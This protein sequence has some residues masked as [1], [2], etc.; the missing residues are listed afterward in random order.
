MLFLYLG[1][2]QNPMIR[3]YL[4]AAIVLASLSLSAQT[5][6]KTVEK[7]MSFLASD[8]LQGRK[9]G[10]EGIDAAATYIE[11]YFK[12]NNVAP[13]FN[14][15]KDTLTTTNETAYNI[16]G[17]VPGT[18]SNLKN[19]YIVIGAHYDHIGRI[20]AENGDEIANGANDNASG[21][22][23]V[24]EY[25]K[26]FAKHPAK[27]SVL[28]VLFSA[29]EAGLLGS[30]HLASKLKNQHFNLYCMVNFEMIGV[31]MQTDHV[32]YLT[33]YNESNMASVLN[34]F[35]NEKVVG[36]LETAKKYQLYKRSDNYPFFKEFGAPSQTVCTFDFTNFEYYHKVDDELSEMD[37]DHMTRFINTFIP[38][39][40]KLANTQEAVVKMN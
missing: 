29:E 30:T 11:D 4:C 31:P 28:F 34:S 35:S 22:T 5:K 14:T 23:A 39:L 7:H 3:K 13:Y 20:Q 16:V 37:F 9:V 27:R 36:F 2:Y 17:V 21:T 18:D 40:E 1:K 32:S 10:S 15:Y 33:G 25:A 24:L 26:Y 12:K 38:V 19:E 6:K 8:E